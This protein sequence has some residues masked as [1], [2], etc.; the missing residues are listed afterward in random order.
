MQIKFLISGMSCAACS[1]RVEKVSLQVSG[2]T[3][4]EVNLLSGTLVIEADSQAVINDVIAAVERAGYGAQI[5][6]D[7]IKKEIAPPSSSDNSIIKRITISA[8][9]LIILMYFTMGHM[10]GLPLPAWY[11]GRENIVIAGIVQLILTLPVVYLNRSYFGK[12]LKALFH[13]APNMDSLIAVGSGASLI[14]GVFVL[15]YLIYATNTG[16]NEA[17]SFYQ[18]QFYFESSAMILT[19]ITV[20]KYLESRAKGR[21]GD[22]IRSLMALAPKTATVLRDGVEQTIPTEEIILGDTVILRS[23]DRI[24]VDGTVLNGHAAVDQSAITGESVPIEKAQ[25][26]MVISGSICKEGYLQIRA[27]RIGSDTTL[28]QVIRLVEEAGG[29]KAPIARLADKISGVFVPIVMTIS[30][31]TVIVWLLADRAFDF[32]LTMGISVLVIS[33]PC[34]LGLATPVAIMVA[35]GKGAS[36][37][38]L[39]KN[40]EA[41]ENIHS[42]DT[43]VLDKTGTV[44]MGDPTVVSVI[45]HNISENELVCL[46][47]A[48]ESKS[49]HPFAKAIVSYA[50]GRKMPTSDQFVVYPGRGVSALV[51]G[52]IIYGGNQSFLASVNI[53]VPK[54]ALETHNGTPLYFG[55]ENGIYLG[56]IVAA[57]VIRPDAAQAVAMLRNLKLDVILLT[58]DNKK[59][60]SAI[61][62]NAGITQVISD[63]L[64][65]D[66]A[67]VIAELQKQE[68]KV[69][70]V[71]DGINDAPALVTADIGMAIGTGTDVAVESADVV[72]MSNSLVGIYNAIT[73]SKAT[74]RN[75]KQ[76]LFWAFIYNILGIPIAA[77]VLYPLLALRLSPM[78][79]AAAMS[80]S[81]VFVV[82]NA[83]RLQLFK[84]SKKIDKAEQNSSLEEKNMEQIIRVEGMMCPHCQARVESAC[85]NVSGVTDA[86]VDLQKKQVTV[87]GKGNAEEIKA[88]IIAAGYEVVGE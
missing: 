87:Y 86:V 79:G 71:G 39:F 4:A 63:V 43:V 69:L 74:I 17:L 31:I 50:E 35:T 30:L 45:P 65:A 52:R 48:V 57:D 36:L 61:A 26:D 5:A 49:E 60:A 21:A 53:H 2:V 62:D 41:L 84:G 76:N 32:A 25:N 80:F 47:A 54:I 68:R 16:D 72:L 27:D 20:G 58:G 33:C 29:S 12:G 55:D 6:S 85:K 7:S 81:S 37:G 9:F 77:G 18:G 73:L 34:A 23:G 24:Q 28:S 83:L 3:S 8:C 44:T 40:A 10:I 13:R 66:K 22:A 19:L 70:M 78:L 82:S 88:A 67:T 1:S 64:P 14:Y 46:A 51:D 11:A 75:I 56:C 15:C 42:I 38:V 59:T